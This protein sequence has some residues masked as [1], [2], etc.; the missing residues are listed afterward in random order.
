MAKGN[1]LDFESHIELKEIA[2]VRTQVSPFE[3]N[4]LTQI[5]RTLFKMYISHGCSSSRLMCRVLS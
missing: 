1:E 4:L 2:P 5:H 3:T